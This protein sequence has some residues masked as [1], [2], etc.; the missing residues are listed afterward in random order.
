MIEYEWD[1][2]K[3]QLNLAKHGLDF[4]DAWRVFEAEMK[5]TMERP[6][7]GEMRYL[8]FAVVEGRLLA[9]VYTL[10]NQAIRIISFRKANYP[11]EVQLYEHGI[12]NS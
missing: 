9:L 2:M 4:E 10:R 6:L 1:E 7:Q 5:V 11:K 12:Q 8:D 3:R